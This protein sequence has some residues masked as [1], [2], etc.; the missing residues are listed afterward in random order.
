MRLKIENH[1]YRE[2]HKTLSLEKPH[3]MVLRLQKQMYEVYG[4]SFGKNHTM[5]TAI[6]EAA[7]VS[8]QAVLIVK[9]HGSSL[10]VRFYDILLLCLTKLNSFFSYKV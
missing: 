8:A 7:T 3:I 9:K 2:N 4:F 10:V 6:E 1:V 5:L